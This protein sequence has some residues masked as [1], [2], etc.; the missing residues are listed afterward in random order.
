MTTIGIILFLLSLSVHEL[1]HA[2]AM[3]RYNVPIKEISIFGMGKTVLTFKWRK[4]FGEVPIHIKLI[5]LGAYVRPENAD[6]ENTLTSSQQSHIYGA[7][8]IANILF[9][10]LLFGVAFLCTPNIY[11]PVSVGVI[12]GVSLLMGVFPQLTWRIVPLTGIIFTIVIVKIVL[13]N[14]VEFQ[15]NSGSVVLIT[16]EI[17]KNASLPLTIDFGER[18]SKTLTFAAIISLSLGVTQ[19]L[20]LYPLDGGR[21]ALAYLGKW[22]PSRKKK[23]QTVFIVVTLVPFIAL[24]L[25]ALTGDIVRLIKLF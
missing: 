10:G 25:S 17:N 11:S 23:V 2:F 3:R 8:V 20:P 7:G 24:I 12:V 16:Q 5:P 18:L 15:E 4:F 14:P 13:A 6:Y 9:A 21:I 19:A 1:G 22:F